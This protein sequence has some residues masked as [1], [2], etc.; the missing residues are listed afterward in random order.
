M[1]L[2]QAIAIVVIVVSTLRHVGYVICFL[3]GPIIVDTHLHLI[4][5]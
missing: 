3:A 4:D 1:P 5:S 2:K